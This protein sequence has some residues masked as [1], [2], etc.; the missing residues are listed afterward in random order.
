MRFKR[1][2]RVHVSFGKVSTATDSGDAPDLGDGDQVESLLVRIDHSKPT[3][4]P[5]ST[6][7][8]GSQKQREVA[9][10][11]DDELKAHSW[12]MT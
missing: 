1:N 9:L 5:R 3:S 7:F 12:T 11:F 10:T 6:A 2:L 4:S 8:L